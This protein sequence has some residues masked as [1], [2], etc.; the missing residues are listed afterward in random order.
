MVCERNPRSPSERRDSGVHSSSEGHVS[1]PSSDESDRYMIPREQ[2]SYAYANNHQNHNPTTMPSNSPPIIPVSIKEEITSDDEKERST[3]THSEFSTDT[4]ALQNL[5]MSVEKNLNISSP[6]PS[7]KGRISDNN[8]DDYVNQEDYSVPTV[9]SHGKIKTVKCKQCK[10]VFKT[11]LEFWTHQREHIKPERRLECVKCPFVTEYKHHLEYHIRNHGGEKP[12]QCKECDY[13]CV[14]KSMLNS[15]MKSHSN[16][17]QYRCASC[18]YSSKYCHSLKLHLRKYN[19]QPAMVLNPDGTPNPLPVIDVYGTRRGPKV[20]TTNAEEEA[21]MS[22]AKRT[23]TENH[24]PAMFPPPQ[25]HQG[26]AGMMPLH[27]M[28][29]NPD[30][31]LNFMLQ[32]AFLMQCTFQ[33]LQMMNQSPGLVSAL[34]SASNDSVNMSRENSSSDQEDSALDLSKDK[35]SNV[36]NSENNNIKLETPSTTDDEDDER[37][38]LLYQVKVQHDVDDTPAEDPNAPTPPAEYNPPASS[39]ESLRCPHCCITFDDMALFTI[40][41]RFH[42]FSDPFTCNSCGQ[43]CENKIEFTVHIFSRP[44]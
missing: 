22:S 7:D 12:F 41:M 35:S 19:H 9:N 37:L 15:H 5:Q 6:E 31:Q 40:H 2:S 34:A 36:D 4:N 23:R 14:N 44:H 21:L 18:H 13:K 26:M 10:L 33:N 17:Y 38:R 43:K 39:A 11:K 1:P 27:L 8:N 16:I 30:M 20:K 28:T 32:Q 3:S 42:N 29:Q 25:V 24:P